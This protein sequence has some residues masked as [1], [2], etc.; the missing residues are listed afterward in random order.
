[1][2]IKIC[3]KIRA[4][5]KVKSVKSCRNEVTIY[6]RVTN[7]RKYD[8]MLATDYVVPLC[9]WDCKLGAIKDGVVCEDEAMVK[10]LSATAK[11]LAELKVK[12]WE[13]A[14]KYIDTY[15]GLLEFKYRSKQFLY[16]FEFIFLNGRLRSFEY[17]YPRRITERS[18]LLK[19]FSN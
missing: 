7:G 3:Y 5:K 14:K 4:K 18:L 16:L 12:V 11:D 1:M 6:M 8:H 10:F 2:S 15:C 9:Y 17:L 19:V 13:D